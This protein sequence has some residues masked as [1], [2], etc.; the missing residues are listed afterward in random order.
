MTGQKTSEA[1]KK[2]ISDLIRIADELL[3][4]LE[5]KIATSDH[6]YQKN[7]NEFISDYGK[8]YTRC[9]PIVRSMLPDKASR[10]ESLYHTNNRSGTNEYTYT[11]QD[12]IQ[13]VYF[14]DKPKSYTDGITTKRL[15]EQLSILEQATSRITDF[16]FEIERFVK[17]NPMSTQP[18]SS[19]SEQEKMMD[20]DFSD[21][22][23]NSLRAE[24][25]S[26]FKR[27]LFVATFLLSKELIRNLLIDIIRTNFHPISDE[28]ISLYYDFQNNTHKGI[29][30]LV[31]VLAERK[32]E[33]DIN[34][35][36]IDQLIEM[37]A[38]I[39]PKIKPGSHSFKPIHTH[40]DIENYRLG[41][42]VELLNDVLEFMKK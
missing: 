22:H 40:E 18:S 3:E 38:A 37:L 9:L 21:E 34:P 8:W 4:L 15:K 23:Y 7:R 27:G 24:I 32:E 20:I 28:E 12:Y 10:F 14:K 11:I 41:E 5:D 33:I 13:G 16:S 6:D 39:D 1:S 25:N 42:T 26:C 31:N 19:I 35:E 29:K 30:Q 17:I 36:A 2:E